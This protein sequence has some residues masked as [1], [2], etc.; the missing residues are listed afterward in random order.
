MLHS[1]QHALAEHQQGSTCTHIPLQLQEI[2]PSSRTERVAQTSPRAL[3]V[4]H[5]VHPQQLSTAQ[6]SVCTVATCV[7]HITT[8][9]CSNLTGRDAPHLAPGSQPLST[10]QPVVRQSLLLTCWGHT[11]QQDQ[12]KDGLGQH[13]KL[14]LRRTP[15]L[16]S[17]IPCTTGNLLKVAVPW[18]SNLSNSLM[19]SKQKASS[20]CLL[21]THVQAAMG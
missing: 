17:L 11:G 21:P 13:P 12:L 1:R 8:P 4:T 10:C 18:R 14:S 6:R 2:L 9:Q 3:N 5:P 15:S 19:V 20:V 16:G 7:R